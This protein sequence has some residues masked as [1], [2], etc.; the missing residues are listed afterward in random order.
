MAMLAVA[1]A[2]SV[3]T[4]L[5][6]RLSLRDFEAWMSTEQQRVFL[7]CVRLLRNADDADTATQDTFFKA[8]RA[9]ERGDAESLM[10]PSKWLTRIAVNT[11]LDR[12]RSLRWQFWKRRPEPGDEAV[13][14]ALARAKDPDP[15][16]T[17]LGLEIGKRLKNALGRLSD[18]QRS[19]FILRHYENRSV[20]EIAEV[21][22]LGIGTVKAH[23]SRA[24]V[25]LRLELKDL[26]EN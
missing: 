23:M 25:K 15:E 22:D 16:Q 20:S 12:L 26:Y 14:L 13:I 7:L 24:L 10:E 11:C 4:D 3:R 1:A 6:S 5:T 2:E 9:M 8:Y 18:Q 17:A 19:V 21:L